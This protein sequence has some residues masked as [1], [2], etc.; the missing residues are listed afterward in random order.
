MIYR[1]MIYHGVI[2][3]IHN[4]LLY[5]SLEMLVLAVLANGAA[6]SG[7]RRRLGHGAHFLRH[8]ILTKI[9]LAKRAIS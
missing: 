6:V 3:D 8:P 1:Q 7:W 9:V 4:K 2:D 5:G